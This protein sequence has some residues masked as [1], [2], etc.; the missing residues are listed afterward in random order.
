MVAPTMSPLNR[1]EYLTYLDDIRDNG[2][3][4]ERIIVNVACDTAAPKYAKSEARTRIVENMDKP[5][6]EI[7]ASGD[8]RVHSMRTKGHACH[9]C[10]LVA[11]QSKLQA[12]RHSY[13][14]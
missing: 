12:Q 9:P 10:P 3:K 1:R 14:P 6:E 4:H 7:T 2:G 13:T 5:K 11:D 8:F